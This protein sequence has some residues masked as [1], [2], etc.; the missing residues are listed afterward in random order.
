ML[1]NIAIII[2]STG[3]VYDEY[4]EYCLLPIAYCLFAYL[5]SCVFARHAR[6]DKEETCGYV[7]MDRRDSASKAKEPAQDQ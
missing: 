1:N 3:S 6:D 7:T 2:I 4:Y 5:P